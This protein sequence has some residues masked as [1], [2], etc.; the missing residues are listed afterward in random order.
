MPFDIKEIN[1]HDEFDALGEQWSELIAELPHISFFL[2]WEWL[3]TWWHTYATRDDKL[4]IILVK[5][6]QKLIAIFPLYR[7]NNNTLRFIGTG[8]QETDEV[9]TEYI[10]IICSKVHENAINTAL[11][12]HLKASKLNFIFNNYLENSALELFITKLSAY[13]WSSKVVCGIS[14]RAKLNNTLQTFTNQC[15][16]SLIKRLNRAKNKFYVELNGRVENYQTPEQVDEAFKILKT[17]HTQRWNNKNA[18][19][20]FGSEKFLHFHNKFIPQAI[21]NNWLRIHIMYA[22]NI[23]IA[24]I[25][26]IEYKNSYFFYQSGVKDNFKPNISPGYLMHLLQIESAIKKELLYYDYMKGSIEKSYKSKL[27]N[28]QK[29]MY[30]SSLITKSFK[31]TLTWI[32]WRLIQLRNALT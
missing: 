17:L 8:E 5:S 31:N 24:A 9:A 13:C 28:D 25:Y 26:C 32:K 7:Q 3:N 4:N 23:A 20:V 10:D 19:G 11:T 2:S 30:N 14:Y 27:S 18:D 12:L 15:S 6:N 1:N 21:N 29:I 22:N 16:K